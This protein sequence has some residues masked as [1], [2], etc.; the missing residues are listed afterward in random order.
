MDIVRTVPLLR[1][2]GFDIASGDL[3]CIIADFNCKAGVTLMVLC[4]KTSSPCPKTDTLSS[5][6]HLMSLPALQ[7]EIRHIL[8][9]SVYITRWLKKWK[10]V[11]NIFILPPS[12]FKLT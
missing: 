4:L 1:R 8:L 7:K 3:K 6:E 9:F 12:S 5:L 10:F 2:R 11:T